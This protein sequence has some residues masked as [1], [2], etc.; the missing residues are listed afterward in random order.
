MT[1]ATTLLP[2]RTDVIAGMLDEYDRFTDLLGSL[3]DEDWTTATRCGDAP[4]R[5][6]AGH[7]V[8]I[9]EDVAGGTPGS[10][11]FDQ[12][13]AAMVG[14]SPAEAAAR[15]TTALGGLRALAAALDDD[16]VWAG[17]S[18][19]PGLTMGK[20]VL[21]LWYD[22][23]IHAD[24]I[25]SAL[26]RAAEP[27]PGERGALAYVA[28]ELAERDF[29]PARI[30]FTARDHPTIEL[31]AAD[32]STSTHQVDPHDFLLAATGRLDAGTLGLDPSVDIYAE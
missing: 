14:N 16:A 25:R 8:G 7:V 24:D 22:T 28:S 12:E 32:A 1:A 29:G 5:D 10:R 23:Y 30:E 20:G 17:P 31:G 21:T 18:G 6:V 13:A 4:V 3:S 15:L 9:V 2:T 19:A 27:G 26:G 11:T